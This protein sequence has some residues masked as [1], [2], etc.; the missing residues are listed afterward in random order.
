[1]IDPSGELHLS[2]SVQNAYTNYYRADIKSN[3]E[4]NPRIR[5]PNEMKELNGRKLRPATG[6][7]SNPFYRTE[8]T[9]A[10]LVSPKAVITA[11]V[12]KETC[13]YDIVTRP[14]E[15]VNLITTEN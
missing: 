8:R 2:F 5:V 3:L 7:N 10:P 1:M 15:I 6:D 9:K 12:L 11:P 13:L 4:G 14:G